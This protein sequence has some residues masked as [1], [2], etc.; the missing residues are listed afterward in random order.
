VGVS[1]TFYAI[2]AYR[3]GT[4]GKKLDKIVLKL[5]HIPRKVTAKMTYKVL[6][7]G[8]SRQSG[9]L[10]GILKAEGYTDVTIVQDCANAVETARNLSPDAILMDV[11]LPCDDS[12]SIAEKLLNERPVPIIMHSTHSQIELVMKAETIGVSAHLFRPITR[13]SLLGAIELGISRFRQC[14][15]LRA[16]VGECREA[17]RI[18]K[19]VERAKGILMKRSSL[20]EEQAF[21]RL[22]KLARDKNVKME[23]V[24][25]S[26]IT[27]DEII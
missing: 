26:I 21:L 19:L 9:R 2:G 27:A 11:T 6:I 8:G 1:F 24:A 23:K 18:R 5:Y 10:A 3:D 15:L 7:I 13:E 4:A 20:S 12:L 17:L 14:Q 22:Q 25:E 16:E